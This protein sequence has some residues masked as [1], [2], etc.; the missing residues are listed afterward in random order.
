MRWLIRIS[1]L[2]ANFAGTLRREPEVG[3]FA[4]RKDDGTRPDGRLRCREGK[5]VLRHRP[6]RLQGVVAYEPDTQPE[7]VDRNVGE[8]QTVGPACH[9]VDGRRREGAVDIDALRDAVRD[10][11]EQIDAIL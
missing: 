5:P 1:D 8:S 4:G 9:E 3:N 6:P 2:Q 11:E 10:Q 7:P